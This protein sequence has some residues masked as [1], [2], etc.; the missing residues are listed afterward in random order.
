MVILNLS[1]ILIV[2]TKSFRGCLVYINRSGKTLISGQI[3]ENLERIVNYL[4]KIFGNMDDFTC[5]A[6]DGFQP[7]SLLFYQNFQCLAIH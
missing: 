2:I 6:T 7:S 4:T 5:I 1:A 3:F